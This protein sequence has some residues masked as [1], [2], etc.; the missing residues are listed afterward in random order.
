LKTW[1]PDVE[2][3]MPAFSLGG[4]TPVPEVE[5]SAKLRAVIA[6]TPE[7]RDFA[8]KPLDQHGVNVE[9]LAVRGDH[10]FLGFRGPVLNGKA[11][12]MSVNIDAAFGNAP[13]RPQVFP[14]RLG[15]GIGVRDLAT[16]A[17]GF[18]VLSGPEADEPGEAACSSGM[19]SLELL[20]PSACSAGCRAR[21]S[22]KPSWF[23]P[24]TWTPIAFW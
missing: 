21:Q 15:D 14:I 10:L 2:T 6:G 3:G 9:G 24:R 12:V 19:A 1:Q 20:C 4:E 13:A 22:R 18:L 5:R 7:L 17:D 16:V 8:E 11:L 23:W